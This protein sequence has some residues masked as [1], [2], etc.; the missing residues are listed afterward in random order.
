[1][2]SLGLFGVGEVVFAS[3]NKQFPYVL[4]HN[5][6]SFENETESLI[7]HLCK[8]KTDQMGHGATVVFHQKE[9]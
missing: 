2:S 8:H 9:N 1:M 5:D 3:K 4:S 7:V 6:V